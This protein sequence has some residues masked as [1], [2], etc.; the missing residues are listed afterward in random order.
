MKIKDMLKKTIVRDIATNIVYLILII[1]YFITFNTQGSLLT[2]EVLIQYTN[3]SSLVFLLIGVM[4]IEMGF[5]KEKCKILI[6]GLEF[7]VLAI[8]TL[9]I[10]HMPKVLGY[11]LLDYTKIVTYSFAIYYILKS[12]VM[13]TKMKQDQ[14]KSLSDIKEIVKDEP[15]KKATKRKNIKEE[16]K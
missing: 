15:I 4:L 1:I 7:L 14:L 10:K 8:F 6:N 11:T 9:L 16:G 3:I 5:R 2:T 12:G 13:Y